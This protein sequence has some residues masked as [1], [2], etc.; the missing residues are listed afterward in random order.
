MIRL[1]LVF[2]P[3]GDPGESTGR[4]QPLRALTIRVE[5]DDQ[6]RLL[7]LVPLAHD[8]A[9]LGAFK[10]RTAVVV[11]LTWDYPVVDLFLRWRAISLVPMSAVDTP[12]RCVDTP[13]LETCRDSLPVLRKI[14]TVFA[15]RA[16]EHDPLPQH[17]LQERTG[18]ENTR[19]GADFGCTYRLQLVPRAMS[20]MQRLT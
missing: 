6:R 16:V 14:L 2:D 13:P 8:F 4:V 9:V 17:T 1:N 7:D 19:S 10:R 18:Y 12:K 11:I 20:S 3:A 5:E 15:A